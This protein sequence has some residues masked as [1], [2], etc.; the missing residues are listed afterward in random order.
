MP[1]I[2]TRFDVPGLGMR[3]DSSSEGKEIEKAEK[4]RKRKN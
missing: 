3:F 1:P 4:V 2:F